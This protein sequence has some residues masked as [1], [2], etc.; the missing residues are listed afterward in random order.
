MYNITEP[1]IVSGVLNVTGLLLCAKRL[2]R[3]LLR[4]GT[5]LF[6]ADFDKL[7]ISK[8]VI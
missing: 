8:I 4:M 1:T 7:Y 2:I 5:P 6:T 3:H